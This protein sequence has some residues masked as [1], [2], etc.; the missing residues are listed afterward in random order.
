MI[1]VLPFAALAGVLAAQTAPTGPE[2]AAPVRLMAGDKLL[3]EGRLFPSPV[4]HDLD[5]DGLLDI[6]VGDLR[7]RLTV[8]LRQPGT[9]IGFAAERP[10]LDADGK[11]IDFHNW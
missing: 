10:M 2:F 4:Y 6:V 8:A 5:G 3:G 9:P 7:G 11:E 1:R